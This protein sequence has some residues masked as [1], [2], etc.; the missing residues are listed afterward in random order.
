[1]STLCSPDLKEFPDRPS[2]RT[3][4]M[5]WM[6]V[7]DWRQRCLSKLSI[8]GREKA[9]L[10]FLGDSITEGWLTTAPEIFQSFFE[11]Y[12]PLCL[13]VGG[14]QTQ[15][16]LWRIAQGELKDLKAARTLFLLIGVN[17][18]G[19][20]AWSVEDTFLGLSQVKEAIQR[21]LPQ[22]EVFQCEILPA[23]QFPN[24]PLREKIRQTNQ[25][26]RGLAGERWHILDMAKV[27]LREDGS[28]DFPLMDD[29][30]HPTPE[31]YRLWA[32][33]IVEILQKR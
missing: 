26:V 18:L 2:E 28:L 3:I 31:G 14:D 16:L 4:D 15:H 27:F 11:P 8:P 6:L 1:M 21:A 24:D 7:S 23:G 17:N 22:V 13:G 12:R 29:F 19:Y 9:K 10:I 20:G 32:Q 25:L 33:A 5:P 30:L